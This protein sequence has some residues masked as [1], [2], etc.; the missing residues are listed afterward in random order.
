MNE[1]SEFIH[2]EIPDVAEI[3][4]NECWLEGQRR[5]CAVEPTDDFVRQRVADIILGGAGAYMRWR[6]SQA[7]DHKSR[8]C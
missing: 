3:V 8:P 5:G 7:G 6:H 2:N 1:E 4:R